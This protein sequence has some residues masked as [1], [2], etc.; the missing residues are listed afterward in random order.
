[1]ELQ[2]EQ[3]NEIS[4]AFLKAQKLLKPVEFDCNNPYFKSKYASLK[5]VDKEVKSCLHK[6]EIEY[7]QPLI[8]VDGVHYVVTQLTHSESGQWYRSYYP[9]K[10][11]DEVDPQKF[12]GATTYAKRYALSAMVGVVADEDD[13]GNA[14]A[15]DNPAQ[16][17]SQA[18]AATPPKKANADDAALVDR[19]W[20]T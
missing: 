13:D 18:G 19:D 6:A 2:S 1:M 14:A 15:S 20:E 17:S 9:I 12:G 16:G 10:C 5:A 11:K 4:K 8:I 7:R 3:I